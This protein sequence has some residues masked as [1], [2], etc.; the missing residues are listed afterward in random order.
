MARGGRIGNPREQ[1]IQQQIQ[2]P[3]SE[4]SHRRKGPPVLA[5]CG[6]G[7]R[8]GSRQ[9]LPLPNRLGSQRGSDDGPEQPFLDRFFARFAPDPSG[10]I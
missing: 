8:D 4:G 6:I 9:M 1:A 2:A 3:A 10:G 5:K 7:S